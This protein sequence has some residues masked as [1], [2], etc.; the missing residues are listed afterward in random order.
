MISRART[1]L[2]LSVLTLVA[3]VTATAVAHEHREVGDGQYELTVGFLDKGPFVRLKNG[4]SLLAATVDGGEPV[5]GLESTLSAEAEP[6]GAELTG[7]ERDATVEVSPGEPGPNRLSLT[8]GSDPP[9]HDTEILLR[10]SSAERTTGEKEPAFTQA[11]GTIYT[12]EGSELSLAGEWE[13][14][15]IVRPAD[16]F[17]WRAYGDITLASRA[18]GAAAPPWVLSG[19]EGWIEMVLVLGGVTAPILW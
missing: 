5:E 17:E 19:V 1:L 13:L 18:D 15:L 7:G 10:V 3:M 6:I 12:C 2:I 14:E 11:G 9:A 4:L 8:L 16:P